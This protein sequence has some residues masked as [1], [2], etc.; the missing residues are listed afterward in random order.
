MNVLQKLRDRHSEKGLR[1]VFKQLLRRH[2]FLHSKLV[3]L[4]HDAHS[5]APA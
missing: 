2:V 3:W 5:T 1:A 4:E